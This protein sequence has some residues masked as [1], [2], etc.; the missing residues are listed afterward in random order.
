[1]LNFLAILGYNSL[2]TAPKSSTFSITIFIASLKYKYPFICA[3]TPISCIIFV[4]S[5]SIFPAFLTKSLLV[6]CISACVLG[7]AST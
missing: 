7:L 6:I 3:G 1:M 5:V 4:I 2:V